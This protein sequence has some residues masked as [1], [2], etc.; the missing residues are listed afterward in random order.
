VLGDEPLRLHEHAAGAAARVIAP[1]LVWRQRLHQ[2][3]HHRARGIELPALLALGEG[4]LGEK[5]FID[6]AEHIF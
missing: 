5:V 1:A 4:E 6:A 3:A 2:H